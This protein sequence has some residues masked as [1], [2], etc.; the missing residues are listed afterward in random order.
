MGFVLLLSSGIQS[1]MKRIIRERNWKIIR[2]LNI[3]PCVP[4]WTSLF[5]VNIVAN[6]ITNHRSQIVIFTIKYY[7]KALFTRDILAHNIAIIK[8]GDKRQQPTQCRC[9]NVYF[10]AI[11]FTLYCDKKI[12]KI[13]NKK[14]ILRNRFLLTNQGKLWK[15]IPWFF[16]RAYL[17]L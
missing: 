3:R 6:K 11:Y 1:I 5:F 7:T 17:G 14:I 4:S 12:K 15:N 8:K 2:S 13:C 9:V 16:F 10:L